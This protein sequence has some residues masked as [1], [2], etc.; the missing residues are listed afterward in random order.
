MAPSILFA[1]EAIPVTDRVAH[2]CP[3]RC[4]EPAERK[5]LA[6][7]ALGRTGTV[8]ALAEEAEVSR[9][10]VYQQIDIAQQALD[11]AHEFLTLALDCAPSTQKKS[12]LS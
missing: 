12:L 1:A 8:T 5:H 3:A 9:K 6:L 10:F 4:M 2:A 11:R 7:Q